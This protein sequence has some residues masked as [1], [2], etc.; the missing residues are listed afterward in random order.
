MRRMLK[1]VSLIATFLLFCQGIGQI[2]LER[3]GIS[4]QTRD[5]IETVLQGSELVGS[6]KEF[7]PETQLGTQRVMVAE[8]A[9]AAPGWVLML[10]QG[11]WAVV[12]FL[13]GLSVVIA[14]LG[15]FFSFISQHTPEAAPI[16]QG[17]AVQLLPIPEPRP[18]FGKPPRDVWN[19]RMHR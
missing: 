10:V 17:P 1:I 18:L 3:W 12:K 14:A 15:L 6:V 2:D 7:L 8:A 11:V 19:R 5:H 9:V 13:V 16:W 4:D